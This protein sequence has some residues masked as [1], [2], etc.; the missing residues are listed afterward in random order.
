MSLSCLE[1]MFKPT[2]VVLIG[3][4]SA[5]GTLGSL[6]LQN[7]LAGTFL[8]PVLLV[9]E[10][11][12]GADGLPGYTS[13]EELPLTP[14]LAIICTPP[15]VV[16][17]YIEELGKRGTRSV[18]ILSRGFHRFDSRRKLAQREAILTA[19]H[20]YGVRVLGP[21]GLGFVS[22]S[23][24]VNASLIPC[25]PLAGKI[26]F[27]SQSD[28]LFST[29]LDW[30]TSRGIGFSHCISL[31]SAYDLGF[32]DLIDYLNGDVRTRAVLLY[33]ETI[34]TARQ[35][36]SA[37]R[38]LA[39][40]KPLLVMKA[41][42]STEAASAAAAHSGMPLGA[43]DVYDAAFRRAGMLRVPDIDSLFHA[44][45]A[46]ALAQPLKGNKLAILTNGGS[47]GFLA[48][49]AL[50]AS[51]GELA[52]LSEETCQYIDNTFGS[53]WSYWNPLVISSN[54]EAEQYAQALGLLLADKGVNAVLAMYVPSP[55]G[56][57]LS[58]EETALH[59]AESVA[60][61]SKKSKKT[62][63]TSWL[64][65]Q[66][67]AKARHLF[68]TKGIPT[69]STPGSAVNA[70]LNLVEF[71]RNQHLLMETPPSLPEDFTANILATRAVF[72]EALDDK[73]QKLH[74]EEVYSV[75][76]AYS[77]PVTESRHAKTPEDVL[78]AAHS[79]G[80]P[81]AIK[82]LSPDVARVS[83]VGGVA[84]DIKS[85]EEAHD[86]AY[87][88]AQRLCS[89]VP[90]A[91]V[92]GYVVQQMCHI[93]NAV[94][95]TIET[96]TDP[97]FGPVIRLIQP[98]TANDKRTAGLPP[99]NMGLA[100]SMTERAGLARYGEETT[101]TI[102]LLLVKVSQMLVDIP[103]LFEMELESIFVDGSES[104]VLNAQI[105]IAWSTRSG[106]DQL[107]IRPYP[108][109][110]EEHVT[111]GEKHPILIRPIRPE[112][113]PA[114]WD[115]LDHLS[116][117][118]KRFRFFGNVAQL[119]R[120]EMVKLTQIDY[121]REMAFI[122]TERDENDNEYTIGVVRAMAS[123]DN[124]E[125]EFAVA[126][127]SD[128]KRLGLGAILM[129]KIITYCRSRQTQRIVGS[130]LGDNKAM[131][132]LA[133]KVGFVVSKDYDEDIWQLDLPLT[134]QAPDNTESFA[135]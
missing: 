124:S 102:A 72:S 99:L 125:A 74:P 106:T 29:V 126:V 130:A 128:R 71:R 121:D 91:R 107:A 53:D 36:M 22:P 56:T 68:A 31:G 16:S 65:E 7:I 5:E 135:P 60:T 35:F 8:G 10:S 3:A 55:I 83:S 132:E 51:G 134:T 120:A 114:H 19:A 95:L 62:I 24:G 46:L 42:R 59:V 44:V 63:L 86:A 64:G 23:V 41:G 94:E 33:V 80:Y 48:T 54:A 9:N 85:D 38:A 101:Q 93:G 97:V 21:E 103:E 108:Q 82:A 89:Q 61:I 133:K 6:V 25:K 39:R 47:P 28:S 112:D 129:R 110:L 70:F 2:S 57:E 115:F 26:A 118:D 98:R 122:A 1:Q 52:E 78:F 84:L 43:D 113:E 27:I 79:I 123:P 75:L 58:I 13:I 37:A 32:H 90:N 12:E 45:E 87:I 18:V 88:T 67:S 30:A 81:V 92:T 50:L 34:D 77:I 20:E 109:E 117:E 11:G 104:V 15:E 105:H 69:F 116:A 76:Q 4:S 66:K 73:R 119:P 111:L 131:A 100:R 49:D 40:N 17:T 96:A 127:R 14:D